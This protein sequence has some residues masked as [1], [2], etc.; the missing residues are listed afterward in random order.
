MNILVIVMMV[1]LMLFVWGGFVLFIFYLMKNLE[2]FD[3][4]FEEVK[5]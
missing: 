5:D 2:E 1:I 3:D 4:V